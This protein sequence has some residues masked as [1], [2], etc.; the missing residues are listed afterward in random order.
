MITVTS[1]T[2]IKKLEN[3]QII[4]QRDTQRSSHF[5][6]YSLTCFLGRLMPLCEF[7]CFSIVSLLE[8]SLLASTMLLSMVQLVVS[9][10]GDD[11]SALID[12][13]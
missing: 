3:A 12:R 8:I 7:E 5:R 9:V 1:A 6:K 13:Q 11:D 2:D 4:F 10:D